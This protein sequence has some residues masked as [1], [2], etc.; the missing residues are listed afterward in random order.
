MVRRGIRIILV[1]VGTVILPL[2]AASA[3]HPPPPCRTGCFTYSVSVTPDGGTATNIRNTTD[4]VAFDVHNTGTGA[5]E[6]TITCNSTGGVSCVSFIKGG[7]GFFLRGGGPPYCCSLSDTL[8]EDAGV[9]RSVSVVYTVGTTGGTI[10][11]NASGNASDSGWYTITA[12]ALAAP[13]V[14][15]RNYNADNHDRSMCLTA[16]AGEAAAFEC[17]DLVVTQGLPGYATLGHDRSLTLLYNSAQAVPKPTVAVAVTEGGGIYPPN[18]V[19]ALLSVS[20][21]AKDSATYGSWSTSPV[22]R[23]IVLAYSADTTALGDTAG[24]YPFTLLVRNQYTG[25]TKDTTLTGNIIIVNRARSRFG[26][27]WSPVGLERLFLA[28]GGGRILWVDGDG[29]AT[30]YDSVAANTWRAAAGAYRDTLRL[31]SSTYTR[32]LRHHVQVVFDAAGRQTKTI[33]RVCQTTNFYWR[34]DTLLDSIVVPPSG[35]ANRTYKLTYDGNGKLD[36]ITDPVGRVLDATVTSNRLLSLKDPDGVTTSFTYDAAGR[37]VGRT[38]RR[39]FKTRFAFANGLRL[40]KD[41][42]PLDTAQTKFAIT[43]YTPWDELGLN[44]AAATDSGLAYTTIDGPR[45]DVSDVATFVVDRWGAPTRIVNPLGFVTLI[46]RGDTAHPASVTRM[47]DPVGRVVLSTYNSRGNV[48]TVTDSTHSGSGSSAQPQTTTYSYTDTNDVDAPSKIATPVDTT[49]IAYNTLVHLPATVTAQGGHVTTFALRTSGTLMGVIDSVTEA[50]VKVVDTTVWTRSL[51]SLTTRF[52]YDALGND[53]AMTLPSGNRVRHRRDHMERVDS[54]Y[55]AA[56]H[57]S[58][59]DHD[60]LNRVTAVHVPEAALS[61]A[62]LTTAY[63]YSPTGQLLSVV[64]PRG[65]TTSWTYDAADRAVQTTDEAGKVETRYYGPSGLLDTLQTRR[66]VVAGYVITFAYDAAGQ[67]LRT[68]YPT[69]SYLA[70]TSIPGDTVIRAYD[71][72]GRPDT[73]VDHAATVTFTYNP[74][75]TVK[76]EH[77]VLRTPAGGTTLDATLQG[78]YDGGD[79]RTKFYNSVDT[80]SYSYGSDG[81]LA[82]LK[83]QWMLGSQTPDSFQYAWDGLGRRDSLHYTNGTAVTYGFDRDGHFRMLCSHHPGGD[84]STHDS[85]EQRLHYNR[86]TPDGLPISVIRASGTNENE[87]CDKTDGNVEVSYDSA[88]YDSRHELLYR[89]FSPITTESETY[90]SSGNPVYLNDG[91]QLPRSFLMCT[92]TNCGGTP[93][94]RNRVY[95]MIQGA[96]S[97]YYAFDQSGNRVQDAPYSNGGPGAWYKVHYYNAINQLVGD[98]VAVF[99]CGTQPPW[100][101]WTGDLSLQY[102]GLGYRTSSGDSI[103]A[104][105]VVNDGPNTI[106]ASQ[107]GSEVT[108]WRFVHGPGTDDPLVT[109]FKNGSAYSKYYYLTDGQGGMLAFTDSLG[110]YNNLNYA[111]DYNFHGGSLAGAIGQ[112]EGFGNS[113]DGNSKNLP[114]IEYYRNR[115]YDQASARWLQEDPAGVGAGTNLYAYAGNNPAAFTDPFGLCQPPSDPICAFVLGVAAKTA[116]LVPIANAWGNAMLVVL[117]LG[118]GSFVIRGLE[119]D[120]VGPA[121]VSG[122][123]VIGHYPAYIKLAK[124]LPAKYFDIAP[125]VWNAMDEGSQ[126]KLTKKF[127]DTG[128]ARGD[129]FILATPLDKV[130]PGSWLEDEINYLLSQ[131]YTVA[132]DGK[133]LV[134]P[135]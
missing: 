66:G 131:G 100:T 24:I 76:S 34:G 89:W 44:G 65:V 36:K 106:I 2:G 22:T 133:S 95:R 9:D 60:S 120:G 3:Q 105:F 118:E 56:A 38:N 62:V 21:V 126:W 51:A 91:S 13:G 109:V 71:A 127:L 23:Q 77:H 69:D 29:S 104:T 8:Y 6:Y 46:Q 85:L 121:V 7:G 68:I 53:T 12:A 102:D 82:K 96:E 17:G 67:L 79:R 55:D 10:T 64:D 59:Y 48:S 119:L 4:T 58:A 111:N 61:G 99:P 124:S 87:G 80:L 5:E 98:S 73:V 33:N 81:R 135:K 128:I 19:F 125:E 40:T 88:R 108:K 30:E 1:L 43:T 116:P 16:G 114:D 27:G 11:L 86:L 113:R 26:T 50:S 42:I 45:T 14:A 63:N 39:G 130:K 94:H 54:V 129:Q 57:L 117:P 25:S 103:L 107:G 122:A 35:A 112:P 32:Y 37:M 134:A 110:Y 84:G 132:S 18:S 47:Q 70:N 49:T 92:P 15:F 83:V 115:Y 41:S 52:G 93:V 123:R 20:G 75:G 90:D 31:A 72:V 101:C 97:T 28:Q 74:E 78:W